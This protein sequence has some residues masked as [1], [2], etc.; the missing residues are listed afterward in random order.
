MLILKKTELWKSQLIPM[1]DSFRVLMMKEKYDYQYYGRLYTN[2]SFS[3]RRDLDLCNYE[4][5]NANGSMI[6]NLMLL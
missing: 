1:I 3:Q 4:S 6:I 2:I 5:I